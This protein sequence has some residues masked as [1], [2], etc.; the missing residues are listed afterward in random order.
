LASHAALKARRLIGNSE[1]GTIEQ[2]VSMFFCKW[3][4]R[5]SAKNSRAHT[6]RGIRF[7]KRPARQQGDGG[8]IGVLDSQQK[9]DPSMAPLL[10]CMISHKRRRPVSI[11]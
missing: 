9:P 2:D 6:V 7:S 3:G 8:N 4:K 11:L 1:Q 5:A 10:V